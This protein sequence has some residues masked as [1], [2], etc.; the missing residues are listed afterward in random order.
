MPK[1]KTRKSVV[2]KFK[3]TAGKK[4][5][6]RYSKQN[7]FN[8]RQTSKL[9]RLKRNNVLVVGEDRKNILKDIAFKR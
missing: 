8:A 2:K 7:H 4:V 6:R 5:I 9:K 3:I 1:L